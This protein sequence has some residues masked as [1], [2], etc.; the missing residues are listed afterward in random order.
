M[1]FSVFDGDPTRVITLDV[2]GIKD[3]KA[4]DLVLPPDVNVVNPDQ[5]ILSITNKSTS[6]KLSFVIERNIGFR[7]SEEQDR[8]KKD[9]STIFLD[10]SFPLLIVLIILLKILVW[11]KI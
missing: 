7:P 6:I 11:A 5:T 2:S 3:V 8:S 10:S 1:W 9:I 4:S